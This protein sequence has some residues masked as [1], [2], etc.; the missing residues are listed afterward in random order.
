[1]LG[2]EDGLAQDFHLV[3]FAVDAD[4]PACPK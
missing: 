1:V 3:R 2:F 4:D